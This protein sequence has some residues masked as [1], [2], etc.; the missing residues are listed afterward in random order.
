[1]FRATVDV[2][3]HEISYFDANLMTVLGELGQTACVHRY[4]TK[5]NWLAS[6]NVLSQFSHPCGSMVLV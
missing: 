1:M 6:A 3:P 2:T 5:L 4:V